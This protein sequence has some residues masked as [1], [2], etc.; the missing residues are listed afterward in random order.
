MKHFNSLEPFKKNIF[1]FSVHKKCDV[2]FH[3]CAFRADTFLSM[4]KNFKGQEDN[5]P[6]SSTHTEV[7]IRYRLL[8][9]VTIKSNK[10]TNKT[11]YDKLS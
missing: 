11:I 1:I 2:D 7:Y 3:F 10:E 5:F 9:T 6:S 8:T 4:S